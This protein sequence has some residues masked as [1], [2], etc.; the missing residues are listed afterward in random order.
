MINLKEVKLHE[1]K[2]YDILRE[3]SLSRIKIKKTEFKSSSVYERGFKTIPIEVSPENDRP[4]VIKKG[5]STKTENS[6]IL[7]KRMSIGT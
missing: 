4:S 3:S 7:I 2:I 5:K 1:K 6:K